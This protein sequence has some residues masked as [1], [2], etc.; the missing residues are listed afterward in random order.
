M[1]RIR[2]NDL[3]IAAATHGRGLWQSHF[4]IAGLNNDIAWLERGPVNVGGRTRTIM[5]DPNDPSGQTVWA[6]SIAGGLW[7]TTAI[8]AIPIEEAQT[9]QMEMEVY[10]NPV[11]KELNISFNVM[12]NLHVLIE[13]IDLNG[14]RVGIIMDKNVTGEQRLQYDVPMFIPRGIYLIVLKT[15]GNQIVR[16]VIIS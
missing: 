5:I 10:P 3:T 4:D 8:D 2:E 11:D 12:G 9:Q 6:G 1:L 13:L 7:K 15:T 14:N 16:K